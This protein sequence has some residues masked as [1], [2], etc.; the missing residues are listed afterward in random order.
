MPNEPYNSSPARSPTTGPSGLTTPPP[1][2]LPSQLTDGRPLYDWP[3]KYHRGAWIRIVIEGLYL[4]GVLAGS[5][6]LLYRVWRLFWAAE[7]SAGTTV[8]PLNGSEREVLVWA[9]VMLGGFCGGC[10]FAMKWLY[11]TVA[12]GKWHT[13]RIVWRIF[14]PILAGTIALFTGLI[15]GSG[16]LP[17]FS[18]SVLDGPNVGAAFG[19][20]V[21]FFSDN[22]VATLQRKADQ[23]LG[24]LERT[25]RPSATAEPSSVSDPLKPSEE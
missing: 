5:I 21:G 6:F 19:F 3:S 14:V 2:I 15:I 4:V 1:S 9:A 16:L 18:H 24:T 7:G 12:Y 22:L 20:F 8:P 23:I 11:H 25:K 17:I 10:A 13:D